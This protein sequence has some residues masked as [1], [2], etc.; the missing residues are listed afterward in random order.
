MPSAKFMKLVFYPAPKKLSEAALL[1]LLPGFKI[2]AEDFVQH[3]FVETL[4]ESVSGLDVLVAEPDLDLYLDGTIAQHLGELVLCERTRHYQKIWLAGISLGCFAVLL[5][6]AAFEGAFE[7]AILL[8]PFLGTPGL[9]AELGRAGGFS[10]WQP[11]AIVANDHER[12]LLAWIKSRN[13]DV[14]RWPIL[15]LGYGRSDRFAA[16]A[17]LLAT[18]LPAE[19]VC[20]VE[21]QHDWPTWQLLWQR[22][23]AAHPLSDRSKETG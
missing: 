4:Q 19:R 23:L 21:G 18:R 7:G 15:Y 9:V 13:L 1:I 14:G 5:T 22:I 12:R 8:S 17:M 6:A 3:G 2:Q 10:S 20:V 11:G 16:G